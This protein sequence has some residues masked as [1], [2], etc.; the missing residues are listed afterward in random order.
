MSSTHACFKSSDRIYSFS[1]EPIFISSIVQFILNQFL[2]DFY[3]IEKD[4]IIKS[5]FPKIVISS[6]F[7]TLLILHMYT[8]SF[9]DICVF[10]V[11]LYYKNNIGIRFTAKLILAK[12]LQKILVVAKISRVFLRK[13][14][15]L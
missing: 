3:G 5:S 8:Y 12:I 7:R 11:V 6:Y 9:Y 2:N 1:L 15:E 10:V 14:V 13:R 4:V